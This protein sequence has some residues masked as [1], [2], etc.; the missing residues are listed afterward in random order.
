MSTS[1]IDST[2]LVKH[3][4][5]S[6]TPDGFLPNI[7]SGAVRHC[8]GLCVDLKVKNNATVNYQLDGQGKKSRKSS[9]DELLD[10]MTQH[11]DFVFP[12]M[13]PSFANDRF[14]FIELIKVDNVVLVEGTPLVN[15]I[16]ANV[17]S[18]ISSLF[19]VLTC[20][21]MFCLTSGCIIWVMVRHILN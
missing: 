19:T 8:S 16:G 17:S 12:V 13:K 1:W 10:S 3:N 5:H 9:L 15:K 21:L 6:S 11:T 18:S 2:P 7:L 4:P 14:K 20:F